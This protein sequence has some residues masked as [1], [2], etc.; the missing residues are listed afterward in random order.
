MK[1]WYY[2]KV[3]REKVIHKWIDEEAKPIKERRMAI[4]MGN[5]IIYLFN[6]S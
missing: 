5:Q 2:K 6:T 3:A 1:Y 4:E